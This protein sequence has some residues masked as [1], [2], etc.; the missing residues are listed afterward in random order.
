MT[1][2]TSDLLLTALVPVIWGSTYIVTTSFLQGYPPVTLAMLRALPAGLFLLLFVRE[3]PKGIWTLR[4][5]VLGALNFSIFASMLFISA[6][7]LPGG[8]AATIG[9]VQPLLVIL[10]ARFLLGD[11]LRMLDII[12][13]CAGIVGVAMLVL[14]PGA[15]FDRVGVMAGLAGAASMA[16]GTVLNRKWAAPVSMVTLGAW[17]LTAGGL[18]LVPVVLLVDAPVPVP[19]TNDLLALAWLGLVGMAFAYV[20]WLRG[21]ARLGPR[22]AT[23]LALLSPLTA[24]LLGWL[25]L[26]QTF[27]AVQVTGAL[28]IAGSIGLLQRNDGREFRGNNRSSEDGANRHTLRRHFR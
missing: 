17:Q 15:A 20:I 3:L 5:F 27:D 10:L 16:L 18:L 26:G 2:R 28:A 7:R 12:A 21:I 19:D 6:Q 14:T 8:V 24:V 11:A 9:A 13:A 4:V 23:S 25:L 22:I 1:S